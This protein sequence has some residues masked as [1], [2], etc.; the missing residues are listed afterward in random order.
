MVLH[1]LWFWTAFGCAP[2]LQQLKAA[3]QFNTCWI[4]HWCSWDDSAGGA[5]FWWASTH[6]AEQWELGGCAGS[7]PALHSCKATSGAEG[8]VSWWKPAKS[9]SIAVSGGTLEAAVRQW[10]GPVL[11]H[12]CNWG[13]YWWTHVTC[14]T[15]LLCPPRKF[16]YDP[17]PRKGNHGCL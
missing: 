14:S 12:I 4:S 6:A 7:L 17:F 1:R 15:T 3:K 5:D 2:I 11:P 16:P 13:W 8:S 10:H 9:E